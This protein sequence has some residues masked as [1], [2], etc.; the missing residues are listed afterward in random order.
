M[1]QGPELT[2]LL[3]QLRQL[4]KDG[5]SQDLIFALRNETASCLLR[6]DWYRSEK[7][8]PI[9]T[10][11]IA[12]ERN[13]LSQAFV[14]PNGMLCLAP[15]PQGKQAAKFVDLG[16]VPSYLRFSRNGDFL[17]AQNGHSHQIVRRKTGQTV[18]AGIQVVMGCDVCD[19]ADLAAYWHADNRVSVEDISEERPTRL[20]LEHRTENPASFCRLNPQGNLLAYSQPGS[21]VVLRVPSGDFDSSWLVEDSVTR[22]LE[23]SPDGRLLAVADETGIKVWNAAEKKLVSTVPTHEEVVSR[24]DWNSASNLLAY[25]TWSLQLKVINALSGR[26]LV[27][28]TS[29]MTTAEFSSDDKTI[30]WT[31]SDGALQF[32]EWRPGLITDIVTNTADEFEILQFFSFHRQLPIVAVCSNERVSFINTATWKKFGEIPVYQPIACEFS[33]GGDEFVVLGTNSI[34]RWPFQVNPDSHL[35]EIGPP[36]IIR[37]MRLTSG[38]LIPEKNMAVVATGDGALID[39]N[40]EDGAIRRAIGSSLGLS[41]KRLSASDFCAIYDWKSPIVEIRNFVTGEIVGRI[42]NREGSQVFAN[43]DV[44]EI[45]TSDIAEIRFWDF[46]A[47]TRKLSKEPI[48]KSQVGTQVTFSRLGNEML[49]QTTLNRLT[50]ANENDL[51]PLCQLNLI[52]SLSP[53]VY[54]NL[55]PSGRYLIGSNGRNLVQ[56]VDLTELNQELRL[57]GL[58]WPREQIPLKNS[59]TKGALEFSLH[60]KGGELGDAD[61]GRKFLLDEAKEQYRIAP[62]DST[63]LNNLAWRTLIAP[64]QDRDNSQSE[65]LARLACQESPIPVFRNTLGLALYRTGKLAEAK[66]V[67]LENLKS[68]ARD[69]LAFDLVILAMIAEAQREFETINLFEEWLGRSLNSNP[70]NSRR[71][72]MEM[73]I[74]LEELH[75]LKRTK[76]RK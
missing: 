22:A 38:F 69:Q 63:A 49:F 71:E 48:S 12:L 26:V 31:M 2:P 7:K 11:Y 34:Q 32:L 44:T 55:D 29:G 3:N 27:N 33:T 54:L 67:L 47:L 30:G 53:P 37:S 16:F 75:E 20:V 6:D 9:S 52:Q 41:V 46:P 68:S 51:R 66:S 61:L 40:L 10:P 25:Q 65:A 62:N 17:V 76:E 43:P 45:I 70:P 5:L 21:V 19:R 72:K 42:E 13:R 74:L 56:A 8:I 57:A 24:I 4:P 23:W 1:T 15:F 73:E 18:H 50:L 14:D 59:L 35:V 64:P 28:S 58:D 39:L 36:K 60:F